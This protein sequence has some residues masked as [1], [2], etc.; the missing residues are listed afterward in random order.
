MAL[1]LEVPVSSVN[2][3]L[4]NPI[5]LEDDRLV[6]C[7]SYW[8]GMCGENGPVCWYRKNCQI[9]PKVVSLCDTL[10]GWQA[11]GKKPEI[12]CHHFGESECCMK[13]GEKCR[14]VTSSWLVSNPEKY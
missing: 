2:T 8:R 10:I 6:Y 4:D 14:M 12:K 3:C 1:T 9:S 5:E 13:S 11:S 7:S